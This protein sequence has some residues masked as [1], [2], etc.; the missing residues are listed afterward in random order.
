MKKFILFLGVLMI[1]LVTSGCLNTGKTKDDEVSTI[2]G[3]TITSEDGARKVV[4]GQTLQLTATVYPT[5]ANQ[6]VVWTSSDKEVATVD[7]KGL[8]TGVK[9]GNVEIVATSSEDPTVSQKFLL[10]VEDA[11]VVVINPESITVTSATGS[12][13][14]KAGEKLSLTAKVLPE[15]AS[16]N[17]SW[18]SSDE[19]I[20]TV[21]KGE[22]SALKTGTV[23]I[24][25]TSRALDTVVGS[26]TLTV[27]AA[28]RPE[29]SGEWSE[30]AFTSHS[31]YETGEDDTKLKIK[32][33]VT[34]ISPLKD[35]LVSYFIQNGSEGY[36]VYQQDAILYPVELGKVYEVGGYK[37]YYKG[38]NE[39]VNVEYF[40]E[41]SDSVT[42]DYVDINNTYNSNYKEMY[43]YQAAYVTAKGMISTCEVNTSKAFNIYV[44]VNGVDA[45]L[46]IDPAYTGQTEFDAIC[47]VL[48]NAVAGLDLEF[49][50]LLTAFGYGTPANQIQIV[51]ASDLKL[52]QASALDLLNA[53]ANKLIVAESLG[54]SATSITLPTSVEGFEAVISWESNSNLID[55]TTGAVTHS[56]RDEVVTL[57]ATFKLGETTLEKEYQVSVAAADNKTYETIVSLDLEDALA[58][59]NYGCS[60]SKPGYAEEVVALGTAGYSWLLRNAL[61]ACSSAD[62]YAGTMGIRAKAGTSAEGTARLEVQQAGEYNVVEFDACTYGT[63]VLGSKVRIEYSLDNGATWLVADTIITL[64][65]Y[66]L[67]TFRVKLPEGVK[68]VA[69]VVV[70]NS[71][72][73]VNF[74]NIKLMK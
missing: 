13:T 46:R 49:N 65:S 16:Q 39:I 12:T 22:V 68:R 29:V 62:K 43:A 26:I 41:S 67:E 15:G 74:D 1:A 56:D 38:L 7:K 63:H 71:G 20:A 11:P 51:K 23:T 2:E 25:A 53:C 4:A 44:N 66:T 33:V 14:L 52:Q 30:M 19:T 58:P 27:E 35:N 61:I 3:I 36:Y 31:L 54:F 69:I 72:K 10:L 8:V 6:E 18:S 60:A 37:K 59:N 28:D 21:S 57:T 48:S 50:G 73:T 64:N 42:F 9:K 5:D 47:A 40:V 34:H 17:V 45:T 70:E 55:V 32:G 24:T